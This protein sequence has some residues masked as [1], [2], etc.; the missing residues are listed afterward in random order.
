MKTSP[1]PEK[2][3]ERKIGRKPEKKEGAAEQEAA[4]RLTTE[5]W[6]RAALDALAEGGLAAV[7]VEPLARHLGVTK[8][9]FYWHFANREALLTAAL[10]RWEHQNTEAIIAQ[11]E[12]LDNPRDRLRRLFAEVTRL[13]P[14]GD[15]HAAISAAASDPLVRPTVERVSARRLAFLEASY[16]A[17]GMTPAQARH[18]AVLAYSAYLGLLHLRRESPNDLPELRAYLRH[19]CDALIPA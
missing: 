3:P 14:A 12:G 16:R 19:L 4:P 6:E 17:L 2:K 7:A 18:R 15:L 8:G 9:S 1:K 10:S 5:D 11:L 13:G